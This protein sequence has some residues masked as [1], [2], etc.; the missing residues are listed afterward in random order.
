MSIFKHFFFFA[1][2]FVRESYVNYLFVHA[3]V[4]NVRIDAFVE[5]YR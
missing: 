5:R 3:N 4:Y 2:K 1:R